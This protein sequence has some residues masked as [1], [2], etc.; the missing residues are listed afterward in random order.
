[1]D[2]LIFSLPHHPFDYQYLAS[3]L[4]RYR[5]P[6][7][8]IGLMLRN[9]EIIRVK[10][11]LYVVPE[12]YGKK[13][14]KMLLSNLIY[15]P[16]YVSLEYALAWWGLIPDRVETV[17]AVTNKRIKHF[18]TPVGVFSYKYI[19]G[20]VYPIGRLIVDNDG[21]PF[22]IASREKALCDKIATVKQIAS[23]VDVLSYLEADLR[24]DL[25]EIVDLDLQLLSKIASV[26]RSKSVSAFTRWY[27]GEI[28][29]TT[30]VR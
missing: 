11:G 20:A 15:G 22:M 1:M 8:K 29:R 16:S 23:A 19:D 2:P 26:N 7:S 17:T 28:A 6:R 4:E 10:K 27:L 5:S 21:Q 14:N 25:D 24:L 18:E 9:G 3:R 13:L 30:D 12:K